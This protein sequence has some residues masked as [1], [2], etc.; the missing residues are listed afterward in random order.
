MNTTSTS[1][2]AT[3]T[4]PPT[5]ASTT[6]NSSKRQPL[7]RVFDD[8]VNN[9]FLND[10]QFAEQLPSELA[11]MLEIMS[12][13]PDSIRGTN[14]QQQW[15]PV[16]NSPLNTS[17]HA[18]S[19]NSK[20]SLLD[21][22][23]IGNS[24]SPSSMMRGASPG[25][26]NSI[27]PPKRKLSPQSNPGR[28]LGPSHLRRLTAMDI[29][30]MN[31]YLRQKMQ[32]LRNAVL[33]QEEI[34]AMQL[35]DKERQL[36]ARVEE[37]AN[38]FQL[39]LQ[40]Q[41][42]VDREQVL[43]M[44]RKLAEN[45]V[46][47]K[48]AKMQT[49]TIIVELEESKHKFEE[50]KREIEEQNK[51]LLSSCEKEA[52][53]ELE[54]LK[55]QF[56]DEDEK[57]KE[58]LKQ[59]SVNE[60]QLQSMLDKME[61][62]KAF[63]DN[64]AKRNIDSM[65]NL[66]GQDTSADF[67]CQ[68]YFFLLWRFVMECQ[69]HE[70][71][72]V[73]YQRLVELNNKRVANLQNMFSSSLDS[74]KDPKDCSDFFQRWKNY[75]QKHAGERRQLRLT[76][77]QNQQV[78]ELK[79][80]KKE[81]Q[82]KLAFFQYMSRKLKL[83]KSRLFV[84]RNYD[85]KCG[86]LLTNVLNKWR[87]T[88]VAEKYALE[89]AN[90]K[91]TIFEKLQN[92]LPEGG[93][94]AYR[95]S[96]QSWCFQVWK[97]SNCD[98]E[99]QRV[100]QSWQHLV[101]L[102]EKKLES[103]S[104]VFATTG[105][106]DIGQSFR[107]WRNYTRENWRERS[108]A[109]I[110]IAQ[111]RVSYSLVFHNW[112]F[113]VER[114]M[115]QMIQN[116]RIKDLKDQNKLTISSMIGTHSEA[117]EKSLLAQYFHSWLKEVQK[118]LKED[119]QK[120]LIMKTEL[121]NNRLKAFQQK[122]LN[123]VQQML[124]SGSFQ[125]WKETIKNDKQAQSLS[126]QL[127]EKTK[128]QE[129]LGE[130]M[131]KN[132]NLFMLRTCFHFWHALEVEAK[133]EQREKEKK[134]GAQALE[135]R[136]RLAFKFTQQSNTSQMQVMF[137]N[138]SRYLS[139]EK[140]KREKLAFKEK[141]GKNMATA[142]TTGLLSEC[143]KAWS[144]DTREI[145]QTRRREQIEKEHQDMLD[146]QRKKREERADEQK[147]KAALMVG[148]QCDAYNSGLIKQCFTGW[149]YYIQKVAKFKSKS[150]TKTSQLMQQ[151]FQ[152]GLVH[153]AFNAWK[154]WY[155]K[156][157]NLNSRDS[158]VSMMLQTQ[159]SYLTKEALE[160][161]R[162][163]TVAE[164]T[165]TEK[166]ALLIK[167][168]ASCKNMCGH[169][170]K[171]YDQEFV[172]RTWIWAVKRRKRNNVLR[173]QL[174]TIGTYKSAIAAYK[175]F[176][177][178][179]HLIHEKKQNQV[180]LQNMQSEILCQKFRRDLGRV[181][182]RKWEDL[183]DGFVQ[184]CFKEWKRTFEVRK[185]QK[186]MHLH[187]SRQFENNDKEFFLYPKLI[188]WK[189]L[190]QQMKKM[191]DKLF[192]LVSRDER[193]TKR[194]YLREWRAH[195]VG[196]FTE[197]VPRIEMAYREELI[198]GVPVGVGPGGDSP[199]L[200]VPGGA[201]GGPNSPPGAPAADNSLR[202]RK[203]SGSNMRTPMSTTAPIANLVSNLDRED[204]ELAGPGSFFRR[205]SLSQ[206]IS[207]EEREEK[208]IVQQEI[209]A[210]R[211]SRQTVSGGQGYYANGLFYGENT[212][213]DRGTSSSSFCSDQDQELQDTSSLRLESGFNAR[214]SIRNDRAL[215]APETSSDDFHSANSGL[216]EQIDLSENKSGF[217]TNS[218][219]NLIERFETGNS[220]TSLIGDNSRVRSTSARHQIADE[221]DSLEY[222]LNSINS[223]AM[224]SNSIR[225][226][227]TLL[228]SRSPGN[229]NTSNGKLLSIKGP[230]RKNSVLFYQEDDRGLEDSS[231][232]RQQQLSF[233]YL[234]INSYN[235][236]SSS[237]QLSN[238]N[239]TSP[240]A[241]LSR[242][243]NSRA[244]SIRRASLAGRNSQN[245]P[246]ALLDGKV[247]VTHVASRSTLMIQAFHQKKHETGV[248]FYRWAIKVLKSGRQE[249]QKQLVTKWGSY[250]HKLFEN[251]PCPQ[252]AIPLHGQ[253]YALQNTFYRWQL[254]VFRTR[255]NKAVFDL[256]TT[257][258]LKAM[259]FAEYNLQ[260]RILHLF[261]TG[262]LK[263]RH[264]RKEKEFLEE[265]RKEEELIK[266]KEQHRLAAEERRLKE[267]ERLAQERVKQ[268]EQELIEMKAMEEA[269]DLRRKAELE[270]E[271]MRNREQHAVQEQR[272]KEVQ[273]LL[274][275]KEDEVLQE[276]SLDK[277]LRQE[278]INGRIRLM[279]E[280]IDLDDEELQSPVFA[281]AYSN[282]LKNSLG[283]VVQQGPPGSNRYRISTGNNILGNNMN[284]A[285]SISSPAGSYRGGNTT[286][287]SRSA[288]PKQNNF[289][290]STGAGGR[291][292]SAG[293]AADTRVISQGR[294]S[295]SRGP[296]GSS[297]RAAPATTTSRETARSRVTSREQQ[298]SLLP[299]G[300]SRG[301]Q[302]SKRGGG[303]RTSTIS[304][305]RD[306]ELV[307]LDY[308]YQK[309]PKQLNRPDVDEVFMQ[310]HSIAELRRNEE[311]IQLRKQ[312]DEVLRMKKHE[313]D[314]EKQ[315]LKQDLRDRILE[316]ETENERTKSSER[317]R[318][319]SLLEMCASAKSAI[320]TSRKEVRQ[321]QQR[322]DF[323]TSVAAAGEERELEGSSSSTRGKNEIEE[324]YNY[325]TGQLLPL[326]QALLD[327][328]TARNMRQNDVEQD[329]NTGSGTATQH[330]FLTEE[331]KRFLETPLM[332]TNL[333][334]LRP[335][336]VLTNSSSKGSLLDGGTNATAATS[337]RSGSSNNKRSVAFS[338]PERET[339]S[340]PLSDRNLNIT[341]EEIRTAVEMRNVDNNAETLP[342]SASSTSNRKKSLTLSTERRTSELNID[343]KKRLSTHFS[344][345]SHI[346][347][348]ATANAESE[349]SK[350][351]RATTAAEELARIL[352]RPVPA[353]SER[354][355]I[356]KNRASITS[357]T[358]TISASSTPQPQQQ[359][360]SSSLPPRARHLS[361]S[362]ANGSSSA[363]AGGASSSR[364]S[365]VNNAAASQ[366]T[367]TASAVQREEE[368]RLQQMRT[369]RSKKGDLTIL[370]KTRIVEREKMAEKGKEIFQKRFK[371]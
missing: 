245:S 213:D 176:V 35:V 219:R 194:Q 312:A 250:L 63:A 147:R 195:S 56:F 55:Q 142:T 173:Q 144:T 225:A 131:K 5:L 38:K 276:M 216:L 191:R 212:G 315:K 209:R 275:L 270:L 145:V 132:A 137:T 241:Q 369:D 214:S 72:T 236:S 340:S 20:T 27:K 49:E 204:D 287:S 364:A 362:A 73:A 303:S 226:A 368:D 331:Q 80:E 7:T 29:H 88:T 333:S 41:A 111:K 307:D 244:A 355:A 359:Q 99:K 69:Q 326:T 351:A 268:Q 32:Q 40:Q 187:I 221:E 45:E 328:P 87:Q 240:G 2:P 19:L 327:Q 182:G 109:M 365:R 103:L 70:Q 125:M 52:M 339:G 254:L 90:L 39:N 192:I 129:F 269:A 149:A 171:K 43:L 146:E 290:G 14:V 127:S 223:H 46:E 200:R 23:L 42:T 334:D 153:S 175:C 259:N 220:R 354:F 89:K 263:A 112:R 246:L 53:K 272:L 301:R 302:G 310:K 282:S 9:E 252:S 12:V 31:L 50:E 325:Q 92:I 199:G 316:Q 343:P 308:I 174:E 123:G 86:K 120:K 248:W 235:N 227:P 169:F 300:P 59:Y 76:E 211:S 306:Q 1:A 358:T 16:G 30:C 82:V 155:K 360:F 201:Q 18:S 284:A 345:A 179:N 44:E 188:A 58:K 106:V 100:T 135:N 13:T 329:E 330:S 215:G 102:N 253:K 152:Q 349:A 202:T 119:N 335:V 158:A 319:L 62:D 296:T 304:A 78:L 238:R 298:N 71:T 321:L 33:K 105:K 116:Q 297:S 114:E 322:A 203:S 61:A 324:E 51:K 75:T 140:Q 318:Y 251:N 22:S 266:Q 320:S 341:A 277:S 124:L 85:L 281:D 34:N 243:N 279:R 108:K 157:K 289:Y 101:A 317:D 256:E 67:Q 136:Q 366:A 186:K 313:L 168:S 24:R 118:Q 138:W 292:S 110:Q 291:R 352:S 205:K 332:E 361:L 154:M 172:F 255:E 107:R 128:I 79:L 81:K 139:E 294:G 60:Q 57:H 91:Q 234:D 143:F 311:I 164:R 305:P 337:G 232:E 4:G 162:K 104:A 285:R 15:I 222:H 148:N 21:Q 93:Y 177:H 230:E 126:A 198:Q 37:E 170:M 258:M 344:T 356:P 48:K 239:T 161:W 25:G 353:T 323:L 262:T 233:N 286:R 371:K 159:K 165:I 95:Y 274:K 283:I 273:K 217:K 257:G 26:S 167:Y 193:R 280:K 367:A 183:Q 94:E 163:I 134:L 295:S 265:C 68:K 185:R 338:P 207:K 314:L 363:L 77:K 357:P 224:L 264:E 347:P 336:S 166:Q 180:S 228:E 54:K 271:E 189:Q 218:T 249:R 96:I 83:S 130:S 370:E 121:A 206:N 350:A 231:E 65:K 74:G 84:E 190:T 278:E 288:S 348:T 133:K 261:Q 3:M 196:V 260:H 156:Q 117:Y 36:I 113:A 150:Q 242:N 210:R 64:Q 178:W 122:G 8:F 342:S 11:G 247:A 346:E 181:L 6:R 115:E 237:R 208:R 97:F 47:V 17:A 184:D 160:A 293:G 98:D 28:T 197:I 141:V 66:I 229:G 267:E 309:T 10:Q 299:P 151:N